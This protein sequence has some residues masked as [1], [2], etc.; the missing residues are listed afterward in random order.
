LARR[1]QRAQ[2]QAAL[3]PEC[4]ALG[5]K[6]SDALRQDGA[7]LDDV[8]HAV[9]EFERRCGDQVEKATRVNAS[10]PRQPLKIDEA[11]CRKLRDVL[12]ES[13]VQLAKMTDK[14][15]MDYVKLQNEVSVACQ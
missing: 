14:E 2:V 3:T 10:G 12:A 4:Q 11:N 7:G 6:A 9:G 1:A 15:K 5:E 8:K 13:R